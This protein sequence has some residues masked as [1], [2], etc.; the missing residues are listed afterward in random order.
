[1][2]IGGVVFEDPGI[3]ADFIAP[4]L[5]AGEAFERRHERR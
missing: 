4:R 5:R 2:I 3:W 1:V